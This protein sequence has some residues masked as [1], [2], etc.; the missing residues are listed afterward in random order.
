MLKWIGRGAAGLVLAYFA[1]ALILV[2]WPT[3]ELRAFG[4]APST[5]L[6]PEAAM[7]E[8]ASETHF[9][10]RD[11]TQVFARL[12]DAPSA[13]TVLMLHGVGADSRG[14]ITTAQMLRNQEGVRVV[15]IDL[16]GHGRSGGTPWSVAYVGQY[17]DDVSDVIAELRRQGS[18][19][20]VLAG[21]S[22]GG[23]I[24]LRH[25]LRADAPVDGYLLIAPLLGTT[26]PSA[27]NGGAASP[28]AAAY[29]VFRTPR[30]FGAL[31][32][33][34]VGIHAFDDLPI[35]YLKQGTERPE[36]GFAALN[37][38]QPNAPNDYRAAL[39]A[40]HVPLLLVAGTR[41]EAFNAAAYPQIIAESGHGQARLVER[42]T[43][44]SILHDQQAI[45]SISQ[46]LAR[47]TPLPAR[48]SA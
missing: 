3:S 41:D 19:R 46:W 34:I 20:I 18:R 17:D 7:P 26:A 12:F 28:E 47:T 11:G 13:T 29:S 35:L 32:F 37:S 21:H 48:K 31:M 25:A 39:K 10:L 27:R 5:A 6:A 15:L 40:I 38:M 36:Y 4:R 43:H 44:N 2:F 22:M 42:A 8:D 1:C 9:Q 14:L 45:G 30:L 33:H 16:R 23:G 24:A